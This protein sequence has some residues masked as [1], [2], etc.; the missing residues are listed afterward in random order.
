MS[1]GPEQLRYE[2]TLDSA[3]VGDLL[4][5]AREWEVAATNLRA[6][7]RDLRREA[8]AAQGVAEQSGPRMSSS[9]EASAG[10]MDEKAQAVWRGSRALGDAAGSLQRA[11]DDRG[12]LKPLDAPG[13]Y[14]GPTDPKTPEEVRAKAAHDTAVDTYERNKRFNEELA[15]GH[16]EQMDAQNRDSTRVMKSI[17]GE[18]DPV[19]EPAGPSGGGGAAARGSAP[20]STGGTAPVGTARPTGTG[21]PTSVAGGA[22]SDQSSPSGGPDQGPP[23]GGTGTVGT[24]QGGTGA[25]SGAPS[26]LG[27]PTATPGPASGAT[28]GG[29]AAAAGGGLVGGAGGVLGGVRG[30]AVPMSTGAAGSNARAIGTSARTGGA[31]TL[32]RAPTG[33][34]ASS[35]TARPAAGAS[36]TGRAASARS[37]AGAGSRGATAAGAGTAGGRGATGAT[38]AGSAAGRSGTGASRAGVGAAAAGRSGSGRE[39]PRRRAD[40]LR[41][42]Q[43]WVGE[44]DVAPGV[45]D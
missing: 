7:A 21:S 13:D 33:A 6:A 24:P 17:H 14:A 8:P 31:G 2:Q 25:G 43:D 12:K 28:L 3:G 4:R 37:A 27:A 45:L 36:G 44:E 9:F 10:F 40:H 23:S 26:T 38:R 11:L 29:V 42:E 30:G 18:P 22:G 39:E 32:G 20:V 41:G 5:A 34:A 16:N 35:T 1:K 19:P 15:R